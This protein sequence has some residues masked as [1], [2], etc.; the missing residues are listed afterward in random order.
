MV[1]GKKGTYAT[2]KVTAVLT[3]H[4]DVFCAAEG[5][6]EDCEVLD[7]GSKGVGMWRG[8]TVCAAREEEEHGVCAGVVKS[9]VLWRC[10]GIWSGVCDEVVI[11]CEIVA[12]L[13]S[14]YRAC[15]DFGS[16]GMRGFIGL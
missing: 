4:G 1:E 3:L 10:F 7:V 6:V 2:G 11:G 14:D 5:R 8:R 12:V 13:F 15:R 9:A 16:G